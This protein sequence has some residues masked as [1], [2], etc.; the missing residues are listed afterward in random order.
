MKTPFFFA[1]LLM[2]LLALQ[3]CTRTEMD[4]NAGKGGMATLRVVPKHHNVNKNIINGKMYIKY[5][6]QDAPATFDD[7]A[8]CISIGGESTATFSGLKKGNYYLTGVGFDTT[9]KQAV[10]GGIPYTINEEVSLNIV[11]PVTETHL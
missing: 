2:P 7:S 8:D 5:N 4:K 3:S 1:L 11:V 10:K 6:A 9:I